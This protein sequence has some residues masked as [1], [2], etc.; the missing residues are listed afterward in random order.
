MRWDLDS[1]ITSG[2]SLPRSEALGSDL[3]FEAMCAQD[4]AQRRHSNR[5]LWCG[6]DISNKMLLFPWSWVMWSPESEK[7]SCSAQGCLEVKLCGRQ[8]YYG[9]SRIH[10]IPRL[11]SF[12][13]SVWYPSHPGWGW[14]AGFLY[15]LPKFWIHYIRELVMVVMTGRKYNR[16]GVSYF[17]FTFDMK[18]IV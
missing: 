13:H 8:W 5:W 4:L 14:F 12:V 6:C 15:N 2:L 1:N 18:F 11:Y 10:P 16:D 9:H 17:I 3:T 7:K